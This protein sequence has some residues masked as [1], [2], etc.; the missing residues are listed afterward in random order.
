MEQQGPGCP[1]IPSKWENYV[2]SPVMNGVENVICAF[3]GPEGSKDLRSPVGIS[4]DILVCQPC[5]DIAQ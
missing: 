4:D 2:G 3:A 5:S 1:T